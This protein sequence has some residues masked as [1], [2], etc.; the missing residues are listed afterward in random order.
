[1]PAV[2]TENLTRTF[3]RMVAVDRLDLRV[4]QGEVFGLLGPNGAGKTTTIK[5]LITLLPPTA[6]QAKVAGFDVVREPRHVRSSIG[7]V[8]QMVS[9]D[10]SLTGYENLLV[11][12][13]LAHVPRHERQRRIAEVLEFLGLDHVAGQLAREYSGGMVRRLEIGQCILSRPAVL[14][15]D[16]P[17]VGLDPVARRAV[18]GQLKELRQRYGTTMV[19]TTHHMDEAEE[20]CTRIGVMHGGRLMATGSP[21]ALRRSTGPDATLEDVFV[22][23]TGTTIESGGQL[24]DVAQVRRTARR[25]A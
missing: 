24:R 4:E 21:E 15:L 14:F 22:R 7:Y 25:M 18:W 13:R 5:M 9:V 11:S 20:L 16:E 19:V 17:T 1:V 12:A 23:Y 8:P 3:G 6:G 10:G 2:E